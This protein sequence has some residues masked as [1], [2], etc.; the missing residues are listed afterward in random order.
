MYLYMVAKEPSLSDHRKR[1][2]SLYTLVLITEHSSTNPKIE[3]IFRKS[4]ELIWALPGTLMSYFSSVDCNTRFCLYNSFYG[5]T[6]DYSRS[7]I[8]IKEEC[9]RFIKQHENSKEAS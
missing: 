6:P 9:A 1:I 2:V 8:E 7:K 5:L 4:Q 3:S